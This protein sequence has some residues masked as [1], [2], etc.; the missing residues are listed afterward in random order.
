MRYHYLFWLACE[1]I[2]TFNVSDECLFNN[3]LIQ[4]KIFFFSFNETWEKKILII[5]VI[6]LVSSSILNEAASFNVNKLKCI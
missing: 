2:V 6:I 5:V 4:Y 3:T 1:C